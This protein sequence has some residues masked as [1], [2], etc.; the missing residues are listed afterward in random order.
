VNHRTLLTILSLAIFAAGCA[1]PDG[2]DVQPFNLQNHG[3]FGGT[4]GGGGV[5]H[6]PPVRPDICAMPEPYAINLDTSWD[7]HT[8][9][10]GNRRGVI[11][12]AQGSFEMLGYFG[13][14]PV[15]NELVWYGVTNRDLYGALQA[16]TG[17]CVPNEQ[18]PGHHRVG[19]QAPVGTLP[20]SDTQSGGEKGIWTGVDCDLLRSLADGA[21]GESQV[22][23]Y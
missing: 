8:S 13:I 3:G 4:G 18:N 6:V 12:A 7:G 19:N 10:W 21:L 23:H 17:T 2:T 15:A 14:D 9:L 5:L 20:H 1:A 11:M 22:C 16:M